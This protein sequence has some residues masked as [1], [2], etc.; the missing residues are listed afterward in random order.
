M[1]ADSTVDG[2]AYLGHDFPPSRPLRLKL[3]PGRPRDLTI[4][5]IGDGRPWQIA[6]ERVASV[7]RITICAFDNASPDALGRDPAH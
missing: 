5:D 6:I 3:E 4:P 2:L 1:L 7:R